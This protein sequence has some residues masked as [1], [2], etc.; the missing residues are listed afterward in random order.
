LHYR[1]WKFLHTYLGLPLSNIKL[2]L[3]GF[4]PLIAKVD[5]YLANWKALLLITVSR[6]V[7]LNVV[8]RRLSM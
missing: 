3:S 4:A 6:V 1:E 2:P 8:L 5:R 7:L